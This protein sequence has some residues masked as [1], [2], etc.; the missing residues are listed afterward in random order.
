[1]A[2]SLTCLWTDLLN[3]DV[4][5]KP[6]DVILL[7][8]RVLVLLVSACH[9][10]QE[11]RRVTWS[12]TN[13]ATNTLPN[14]A[15]ETEA[16]EIILFGARFLERATKRSEEEKVLTIDQNKAGTTTS[17]VPTG[18]HLAFAVF[19]RVASLQGTAA[20]T[21]GSSSRTFRKKHLNSK[22]KT[23]G[24]GA[25]RGQT[26]IKLCAD[27]QFTIYQLCFIPYSWSVRF[28]NSRPTT[29]LLPQLVENNG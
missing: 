6:E 15:E 11:K 9:V 26:T 5:V 4:T 1:M 24:M 22:E 29:T 7:L 20:R 21:Q 18:I 13:P 19:W 14:I 8:Q 17:K 25:I 16:K 27:N 23:T 10:S 3:L 12:Q 28:P 2:G